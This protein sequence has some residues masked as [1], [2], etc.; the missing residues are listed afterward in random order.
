VTIFVSTFPAAGWYAFTVGVDE[1][2]L[3]A[4]GGNVTV[5]GGM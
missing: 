5:D 1:Q 2:R 3:S 4:E